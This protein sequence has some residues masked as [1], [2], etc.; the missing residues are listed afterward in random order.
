MYD[1]FEE[2]NYCSHCFSRSV[3]STEYPCN[4]C[5][6]FDMYEPILEGENVIY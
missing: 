3:K 2:L 5:I 4:V 6:D 1:F